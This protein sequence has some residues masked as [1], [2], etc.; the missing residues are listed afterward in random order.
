[1]ALLIITMVIRVSPVRV[2]MEAT[3][4]MGLVLTARAAMEVPGQ[5]VGPAATAA[6]D[7]A[8]E[9]AVMAE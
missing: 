2:E 6:T 7:G 3:P 1:M 5:K 4:G 8:P 9:R